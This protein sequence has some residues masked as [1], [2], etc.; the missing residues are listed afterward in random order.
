[1]AMRHGVMLEVDIGAKNVE[2]LCQRISP[3]VSSAIPR[4][5]TGVGETDCDPCSHPKG[6]CDPMSGSI[7][8]IGR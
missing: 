7:R 1:M 6:F 4:L 2:T 3:N 8:N 5:A